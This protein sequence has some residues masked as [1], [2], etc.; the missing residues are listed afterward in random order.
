MCPPGSVHS[1]SLVGG[2]LSIQ[3]CPGSIWA[4]S[5]IQ[6][7]LYLRRQGNYPQCPAGLGLVKESILHQSE[8]SWG[9]GFLLPF[10]GFLLPLFNFLLTSLNICQT[11]EELLSIDHKSHDMPFALIIACKLFLSD[12][13]YPLKSAPEYSGGP[14]GVLW[15][16]PFPQ[17][18]EF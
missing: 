16:P 6:P 10:L 17:L 5:E 15:R 14:S 8:D 3:G 12:V 11:C 2:E 18:R 7:L 1:L 9:N 13:C 4:L